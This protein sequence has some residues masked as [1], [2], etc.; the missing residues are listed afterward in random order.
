[1]IKNGYLISGKFGSTQRAGF[2]P[3]CYLMAFVSDIAIFV[4]K[5]DVKLQLT[6]YLMA[7][8]KALQVK[9]S[10]CCI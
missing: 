6:N 9:R 2:W 4:L 7:R 1:V 3:M 10:N 5:R 8:L